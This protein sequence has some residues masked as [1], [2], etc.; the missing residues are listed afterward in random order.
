[1]TLT[2]PPIDHLHTIED[3]AM[4]APH[5]PSLPAAFRPF[6]DAD[7]WARLR[8][9]QADLQAR[10]AALVP[11]F[12]TIAEADRTICEQLVEAAHRCAVVFADEYDPQG[13]AF[14]ALL[15]AVGS[16][17]TTRILNIVTNAT[18]HAGPRT[19][20]ELY[21]LEQELAKENP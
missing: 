14:D 21:A 20:A 16:E 9:E 1:M 2:A 6:V 7:T 13:R 11:L 4:V 12:A 18:V 5:D 15:A 3:F 17:R 10:A 8:A 19:R